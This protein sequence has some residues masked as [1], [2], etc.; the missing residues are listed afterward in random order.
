MILFFLREAFCG[1]EYAENTSLVH[2]ISG[3]STDRQRSRIYISKQHNAADEFYKF[4][5][6][7]VRLLAMLARRGP[8][9]GTAPNR[10][11]TP[12]LDDGDG[13][14]WATESMKCALD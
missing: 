6:C 2:I 9:A 12:Q 10:C 1:L 14:T 5:L 11:N 7:L 4:A 8:A 3:Y 13:G